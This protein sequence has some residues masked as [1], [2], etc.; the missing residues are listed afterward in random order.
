LAFFVKTGIKV[1]GIKVDYHCMLNKDFRREASL[2]AFR[3]VPFSLFTKNKN[4][5]L[6]RKVPEN[7]FTSEQNGLSNN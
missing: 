7:G 5:Q 2:R 1:G 3:F 4:G 6:V